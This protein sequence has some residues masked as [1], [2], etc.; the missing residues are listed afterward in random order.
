LADGTTAVLHHGGSVNQVVFSPDGRYM[1]TG[2]DDRIARVFETSGWSLRWQMRHQSPVPGVAFSWDRRYVISGGQD[3]AVQVF[4]LTTGKEVERL[5]IPGG[6]TA[7]ALSHEDR[8]IVLS[9]K[10]VS[11]HWGRPDDLIREACS[12]VTGNLSP[13]EWKQFMGAEPYRETC[14]R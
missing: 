4:D 14:P 3:D 8:I 7:V 11:G 10:V 5:N 2:S 1:A 6:I 12:R 9:A 13:E